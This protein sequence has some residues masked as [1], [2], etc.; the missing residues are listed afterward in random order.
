MNTEE[1]ALPLRHR[2]GHG[3]RR[4]GNWLQLVRF[5]LVGASGYAVNLA[6]FSVLVHGP[7]VNFRVA[8]LCAFLVAVGNNFLWNRRWTFR[9]R[10]GHDGGRRDRE[11]LG[12]GHRREDPSAGRAHAREATAVRQAPPR[13]QVPSIR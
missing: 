2:V 6:V 4:P 7:G 1:L 5:A 12:D 9:A 11:Q 13:P 10:D 3:I 8:A